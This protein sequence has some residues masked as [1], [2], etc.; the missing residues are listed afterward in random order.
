MP[1]MSFLP[2]FLAS[3]RD[4][5]QWIYSSLPHKIIFSVVAATFHLPRLPVG[6]HGTEEHA[7][8][9][10]LGETW[11]K[12]GPHLIFLLRPTPMMRFCCLLGVYFDKFHLLIVYYDWLAWWWQCQMKKGRKEEI[13]V[14]TKCECNL[15]RV[16]FISAEHSGRRRTKNILQKEG[17][18]RRLAKRPREE[19]P[20]CSSLIPF[21]LHWAIHLRRTYISILHA[22]KH[23]IRKWNF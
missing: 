12:M 6:C 19:C 17:K 21:N 9:L 14:P 2:S 16:L 23:V 5:V 8:G 18:A 1:V 22:Q 10:F 11:N 15:L 20:E 3:P 7:E 13:Q 4:T